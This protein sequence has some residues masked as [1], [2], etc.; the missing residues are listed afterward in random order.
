MRKLFF[1]TVL[2]LLIF[3]TSCATQ[4]AAP[5]NDAIQEPTQ[6]ETSVKTAGSTEVTEIT[7]LGDPSLYNDLDLLIKISDIIIIGTVEEALPVVR[8]EAVSLGLVS[9][10][11][12]DYKNISSYNIK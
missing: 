1:A 4:P 2:V 10:S 6:T 9:G 11:T 12:E 3:C 8:V 5:A 7:V